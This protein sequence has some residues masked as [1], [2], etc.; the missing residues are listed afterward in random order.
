LG[1]WERIILLFSA[2]SRS[3]DPIW[4]ESAADRTRELCAKAGFD[5]RVVHA[6][7][8]AELLG[9]A[10]SP[11]ELWREFSDRYGTNTSHFLGTFLVNLV[12]RRICQPRTPTEYASSSTAPSG[13]GGAWPKWT[14]C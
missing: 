6:D 7:D 13:D 4:P 3:M 9:M 11:A 8:T 14:G 2:G 12:G 5:H 1:A 10:E